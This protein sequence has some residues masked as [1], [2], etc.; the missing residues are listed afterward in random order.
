MKKAFAILF[1]AL[2]LVSGMHLSVASHLCCGE[3]AA[4]KCSF[5]GEK[6]TCGME[7][8][9]S[10]CLSNGVIEANCCKNQVAT[11]KADNNY[12]PTSIEAKAI[13]SIAAPVYSAL[14]VFLPT[15]SVLKETYYS[16]VGP[17][18]LKPFNTVD[19]SIICVFII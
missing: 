10:P 8:H 3:L 9:Q 15:G 18:V 2:V 5:T 6:A 1:A 12:F 7:D 17:P 14:P 13:N 11:C 19:R 16:M 4:V